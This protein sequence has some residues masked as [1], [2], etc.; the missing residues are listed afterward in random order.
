MINQPNVQVTPKTVDLKSINPQLA[1]LLLNT[2]NKTFTPILN[3]GKISGMFFVIKRAGQ[4][5]ISYEEA[6]QS[7]FARVLKSKEQAALI[8]YFEKK[9]SEANIKI[10]RRPN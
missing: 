9:K 4:K 1:G 10:V 8:E 3:L 7:I 5:H 2:K 6:K